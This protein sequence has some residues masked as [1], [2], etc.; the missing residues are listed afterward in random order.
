MTDDDRLYSDGGDE[1]CDNDDND[2]GYGERPQTSD[3]NGRYK[4]SALKQRQR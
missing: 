2:D 3:K 4:R 1:N